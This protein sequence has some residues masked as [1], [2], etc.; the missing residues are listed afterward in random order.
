MTR[1]PKTPG[2]VIPLA[3]KLAEG[4]PR[5]LAPPDAADVIRTACATGASKIG[6]AM[7]LACSIDVL[8]RWL[9]EDAALKEAFEHGRERERQTLHSTLYDA[10]TKGNNIVA[11]M[12]LLKS[13]HGYQEGQQ[14]NQSNKVSVTF[15]L[16]GAL[17]PEQF[18]IENDHDRRTEN[19]AL[20][21][22]N[23]VRS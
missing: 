13:R 22:S 14:E 20:P 1:K 8:N 18:T 5:K 10:A 9:D 3:D 2:R 7:A 11:A 16:P 19:I 12:F 15:N 23:L 21:K 17:Q 4:R 6:V